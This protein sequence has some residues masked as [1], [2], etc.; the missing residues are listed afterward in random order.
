ME[1]AEA[2]SFSPRV[3]LVDGKNRPLAPNLRILE[4]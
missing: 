4:T 2:K 3:L 1:E